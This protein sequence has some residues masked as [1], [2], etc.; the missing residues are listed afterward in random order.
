M[1]LVADDFFLRELVE[2]DEYNRWVKEIKDLVKAAR[3]P[4]A[5]RSGEEALM[6]R[7]A[8]GRKLNIL[9]KHVKT[10]QKVAGWLKATFGCAWPDSAELFAEFLETMVEEP[11]AR[12][13]PESAYKMLMFLE[14][15]GEVPEEQ[16]FSRS[17][18]IKNALEESALRLQSVELK[19]AKK[20]LLIPVAIV[21]AWEAWVCNDEASNYSR[22]YAWFRLIKFGTGMRFDDTKGTPNRTMELCE[23]GL[24]GVIH[25]SKTSGPGKRI[26]LL[27]FY[28]GKEAWICH[29][30]WLAVGWR[31][32]NSMG[33]EAGM[34][35]RDFMFP[36]PNRD[37]SCFIRKVVDYPVASTMSQALFGEIM[38]GRGND[39]GPVLLPGLGVLWSEHSEK[40]HHPD[41]GS[42]SSHP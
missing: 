1:H 2:R 17:P 22:A 20:A 11:C 16:Q 12:N 21:V 27:P 4:V 34:L 32:W 19:P 31:F 26:V 15:I 39:R 24:K 10:W 6:I 37:R 23:W 36:W 13:F 42:G 30:N 25:R 40:G 41:M 9:R 29:E 38:V 3:L 33:M 5:I 14:Y 35:M 8:K 7:V 18:A 28:L